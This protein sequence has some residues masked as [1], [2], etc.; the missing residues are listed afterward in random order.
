MFYLLVER[1]QKAEGER[2][3]RSDSEAGGRLQ[4]PQKDRLEGD[5]NPPPIEDHRSLEAA[6]FA[7]GKG[8][9]LHAH[10]D[11][12]GGFKPKKVEGFMTAEPSAICPSSAASSAFQG[13]SLGKS[14]VK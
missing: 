5:S 12:G 9:A 3:R 1:R 13:G 2:L 10:E 8:D 7:F 11:F 4:P 14:F 6:D